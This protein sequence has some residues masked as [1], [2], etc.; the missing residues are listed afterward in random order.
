MLELYLQMHALYLRNR[1]K[2]REEVDM[3]EKLKDEYTKSKEEDP[4]REPYLRKAV[5]ELLL[6]QV[7]T[8]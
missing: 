5:Y 3:V 8:I 6:I 2:K 7:H 1:G 4:D